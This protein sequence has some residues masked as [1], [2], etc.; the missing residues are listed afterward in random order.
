MDEIADRTTPKFRDNKPKSVWV[1]DMW[2]A[3]QKVKYKRLESNITDS[4]IVD[5]K[6]LVVVKAKIETATREIIQ[7]EIYYLIKDGDR[8]FI[9]E[10][11]V[12]DKKV[13]KRIVR[14]GMM[15][16]GKAGKVVPM[17]LEEWGAF[18]KETEVERE[19]D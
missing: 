1:V 17:T 19:S 13:V 14:P 5:N 9:D 6:F 10:M 4:K 2:K 7:K 16:N 8:W 18:K 3:L 15:Y 12:T 11:I